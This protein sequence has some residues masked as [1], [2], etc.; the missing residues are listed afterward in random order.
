MVQDATAKLSRMGILRRKGSLIG[1]V[2]IA[3]ASIG[4]TAHE[5]SAAWVEEVPYVVEATALPPVTA[6]VPAAQIVIDT[7]AVIELSSL[8]NQFLPLAQAHNIDFDYS[9]VDALREQ[10]H[11]VGI[12]LPVSI[13][14]PGTTNFHTEFGVTRLHSPDGAAALADELAGATQAWVDTLADA[15]SIGRGTT[16]LD[17]ATARAADLRRAAF[18]PA[19]RSGARA[20][21]PVTVQAVREMAYEFDTWFESEAQA[22]LQSRANLRARMVRLSRAHGNGRLPAE[23]LCPIP[24]SPRFTMR[25]DVIESLVELNNAFRAHF[26]RDLVVRSG[27]RGNPGTSNHGWGLAIDF[28]GQMVNFGTSEFNWMIAN[29]RR[30]GWGHAFWAVPGGIN[31]QPWHWEAMDEVRQMTGSW[32]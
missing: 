18:V 20:G 30:F 28:G 24:F 2:V 9:L 16:A 17:P 26:G 1:G 12:P 10:S 11:R 22:A 19:S 7:N 13:T 25:C 6:A 21:Q 23:A 14:I 29:A 32:R 8:L 4:L 27:Y 15:N 3:L 31:P 5:V